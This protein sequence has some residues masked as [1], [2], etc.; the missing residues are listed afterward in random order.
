MSFASLLSKSVVIKRETSLVLDSVTMAAAITATRQPAKKASMFITVAGAT[1]PGVVTI[2]G[3]VAGATV[4]EAVSFTKDESISGIKLFTALAG[5]S[6]SGFSSYGT[7]TVEGF[8]KSGKPIVSLTT[9]ATIRARI[10]RPTS[11]SDVDGQ[12]ESGRA[13]LVLYSLPSTVLKL[14]DV[15]VDGTTQYQIEEPPKLIFGKRKAHHY[16]ATLRLK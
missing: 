10:G 8:T 14:G 1:H 16:E 5:F 6:L 3:T 11:Y 12:G 9:I 7:M 15:V 2:H 13:E 4:S